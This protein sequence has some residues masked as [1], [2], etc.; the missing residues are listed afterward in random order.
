MK[1]GIAFAEILGFSAD[2]I[3]QSMF[4]NFVR[5][6]EIAQLGEQLSDRFSIS[7]GTDIIEQFSKSMFPDVNVL[8]DQARNF[9][10]FKLRAF[11]SQAELDAYIADERV[12]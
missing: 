7:N 4:T 6:D 11:D 8:M 10:R 5:E 1:S 2:S 3:D 9:G 12:G